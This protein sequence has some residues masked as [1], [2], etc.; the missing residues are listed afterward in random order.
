MNRANSRE[1]ALSSLFAVAIL[2]VL[3]S[4]S[5][6]QDSRFYIGGSIGR[7]QV[8]IDTGALANETTA[9]GLSNTGYSANNSDTGWKLFA[10]YKFHPNFAVEGG[11]VDLGKFSANTNITAVN[12]TPVVPTS[13]TFTIKASEGFFVSG[14]GVWPVNNQFSVFGKLGGYNMKTEVTASILGIN[15]SN[16]ARNNGWLFGLGGQFDFTKNVGLRLEW[17]R[18]NKVGDKDK[19]AQGDVDLLSLGLV[20]RFQ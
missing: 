19:T 13:L 2:A 11:Y 6:A 17:E 1:V 7:S 10:G 9:A 15:I 14:L 4:I 18:F 16:T 12:G 20:Y 5:H 8:K 3:P